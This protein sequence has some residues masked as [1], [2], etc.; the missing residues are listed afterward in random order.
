[1]ANVALFKWSAWIF[2]GTSFTALIDTYRRGVASRSSGAC[3][4]N[5]FDAVKAGR[6]Y[7]LEE[8]LDGAQRAGGEVNTADLAH[9]LL[10]DLWLW[11]ILGKVCTR[12]EANAFCQCT[13]SRYV[14]IDSLDA[15]PSANLKPD[16]L[17]S[18]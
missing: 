13:P 9:V 16:E 3:Q 5:M 2:F 7:L 4:D 12:I 18:S 10:G 6:R 1:M 17:A 8:V 14:S 15:H 11:A